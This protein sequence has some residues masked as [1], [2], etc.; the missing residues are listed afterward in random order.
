MPMGAGGLDG[1][2][3]SEDCTQWRAARGL[4]T[5]HFLLVLLRG[6]HQQGGG[7]AVERVGRVGVEQQLWQK[8]FKD[9][10]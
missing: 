5:L 10:E 9:V 3:M 4:L 2:R 6:V 7:L 8:S 1:H